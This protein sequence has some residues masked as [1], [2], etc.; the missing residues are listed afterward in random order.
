MPKHLG[1]SPIVPRKT[2]RFSFTHLAVGSVDP[3]GATWGCPPPSRA[4]PYSAE[5]HRQR[6]NRRITGSEARFRAGVAQITLGVLAEF[7]HGNVVESAT[8]ASGHSFVASTRLRAFLKNRH[9]R[10]EGGS[11]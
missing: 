3:D 2:T 1:R 6:K 9:T 10:A 8:A 4:Q 11:A 5:L 7:R